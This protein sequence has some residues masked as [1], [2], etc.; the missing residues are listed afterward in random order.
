MLL[1]HHPDC[2]PFRTHTF[3][4]RSVRF[5]IGC[6]IG[7]PAAIAGIFLGY[8]IIRFGSQTLLPVG[9][10][11]VAFYLSQML[12]FW[13]VAEKKPVKILQK[14]MIGLGSGF[15]VI[16]AFMVTELWGIWHIIVIVSLVSALGL[17]VGLLHLLK[18]SRICKQCGKLCGEA[19]SPYP[20]N[21]PAQED[22][23]IAKKKI[24]IELQRKAMGNFPK[25]RR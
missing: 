18:T 25:D 23:G 20:R 21:L 9:L 1:A 6:F 22:S 19:S 17:P 2:P 16:T 3:S 10:V 13:K 12:S 5:C 7:Y 8:F 4:I 14:C 24:H 15:L 11:G